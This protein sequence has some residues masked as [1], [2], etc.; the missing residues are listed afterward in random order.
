MKLTY[1]L[2]LA[3]ALVFGCSHGNSNTKTASNENPTGM[4]QPGSIEGTGSTAGVQGNTAGT[5]TASNTQT[6]KNAVPSDSNAQPSNTAGSTSPSDTSSSTASNNNPSSQ[7]G[8]TYG[9]SGSSSSSGTASSGQIGSTYGQ[10]N[11]GSTGQSGTST[12]GQNNTSSS[13]SMGSSGTT[14]TTGST[15]GQNN[16]SGSSSAVTPPTGSTSSS[17]FGPQG[18]TGSA[19]A[20]NDKTGSESLKTV[21]G[22][23]AKV[24]QNSI[25]LDQNAGGVTLT[26]DSNTQVLRRGQPIAAGI[27][28]IHEG[29]QVR[30][31]FD[32][33]SN[34][35]DKI[36]VMGR[37]KHSK[38]AS[39]SSMNN[40]TSNSNQQP[41]DSTT[42]SNPR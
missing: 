35:A 18:P 42:P 29:Q 30:A 16:T 2:A 34:R 23:V 14:G 21:T 9:Q 12:Y 7:S 38:K 25:T 26:I 17:N 40:D 27:S 15:Y 36:E 10:N 8:S 5:A 31:S 33:A 11:T 3:A 13:G 1:G 28:A 41:S 19:T 4:T 22:S 37:T 32:P 24:D 6:S 39:G 20:S